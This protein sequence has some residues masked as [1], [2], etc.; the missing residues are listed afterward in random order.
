MRS[1]VEMLTRVVDPRS[2]RGCT[3]EL[4]PILCL[5]VLAVLAGRSSLQ[6]I[7]QFGRD[8]GTSLAHALGFRRSKTPSA[9]TL[10]RVFR[11]LDIDAFEAILQEWI[12]QRCPDLGEPFC[13]DGKT[14]RCSHDGDAPA[15]HLLSLFAPKVEAVVG[16]VRV[17]A[18]TNEHKAALR[19]LG[20]LPLSGTIV[21]GDAMFCQTEVA[22]RV[23]DQGGD[24]LW[25]VKDNQPTVRAKI[26]ELLDATASFP[27]GAVAGP[28]RLDGADRQQRPRPHR[29]S[30]R[31]VQRPLERLAASVGL[32][33]CRASHSGGAR[34]PGQGRGNAQCGL[35]PVEPESDRSDGVRFPAVD[36]DPLGNR[37]QTA[38]RPRC[39]V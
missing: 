24:Y 26:G 32:R 19:L 1:L 4:V 5:S 27:P 12:V 2:R 9:S 16:Q 15:V 14:L 37:K 23:V 28:R 30:H 7:A 6:G 34:S 39:H 38:P 10:S 22:Q 3:H 11:R 31:P 21:T 29:S 35:L 17:D 25:H 20:L 8:H 18:K 13:L 33:R 36:P